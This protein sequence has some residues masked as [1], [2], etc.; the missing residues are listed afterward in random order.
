MKRLFGL[1]AKSNA[2]ALMVLFVLGLILLSGWPGGSPSAASTPSQPAVATPP[3]PDAPLTPEQQQASFQLAAGL[4]IDVIASEP[5]VESPV[6]CAFDEHARLWVAEYRDYPNG[7]P[8]GQPGECRIKVLEDT[9]GDGRF[10]KATIFADNLL[11]ANGVL[12]WKDGAIVTM[13]PKIVYLRDTDGDLK[14]DQ[15]EVLYEGFVAGNPQLRVSHPILGLDGWIYVA[16]GLR[17][18]GEVRRAGRTDQPGITLAGKD[19]RF[20]LLHD[21]AEAIP[22]MGQFGNTFDRWGHRFVCDNR[23]HLRHVV[24]AADPGSR[25]PLLAVPSVLQDTAGAD[26][27][28]IRVYPL[29]RNWTTSNLHAGQFTAACGV[30]VDKGGLLPPP[31]A[32][33]AFC[34]E[35]TGNLVH[36]SLLEP[37]GASFRS[38]PWKEGVEFLATKDEWFRPVS[39]TNAPDG[40][41]IVVDMYRAVIE[42][43]EFMPVELKNRPDLL[44]GKDRGRIWRIAPAD[45]PPSR[46]AGVGG[47]VD[48]LAARLADANGWVRATAQRLLLQSTDPK[49][50][51]AIARFA[52]TTDSPDA[53]I[54]AAYLLVMKEHSPE[55]VIQ[56]ML[57]HPRPE[58]QAHA[59]GLIEKTRVKGTPLPRELMTLAQSPSPAVRFAAAVALGAWD[60]PAIIPPLAAIA[61]KDAGDRWARLAVAS[62]AGQR[63]PELVALLLQKTEPTATADAHAPRMLEEFCEVIGSSRQKR[64]VAELL[65]AVQ[66]KPRAVQSAVV[67][68]LAEGVSRR[69]GSFTEFL[70]SVDDPQAN[71][72]AR[73]IL[74]DLT[75]AA[76]D[77]NAS[78]GERLEALR[79]MA[80]DLSS[81]TL[82]FLKGLI[83]DPDTSSPLKSAAIRALAGSHDPSLAEL[84]LKTWRQ[85]TPALRGEALDALLRRPER[86]KALLDAVELGKLKPADIDPVRAKRLMALKDK[87]LAERAVRLLKDSLPADRKEVLAQYRPALSL[88]ADAMRGLEA[89]RKACAACHVVNG[90]G[91]AVGP[92]ISDTRTKTPEMLLTD[93]LNPNAAI[94]ANYVAYTVLTRDGK[95]LQGIIA[96]ESAAS[97]TLKRENNQTDTLLRADIEEIRSSGQSLMPEGLEKNLSVQEMADLLRF[98][99]DWRYLDGRTPRQPSP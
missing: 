22:G 71:T 85:L 30:Y 67:R 39:L 60:E 82:S 16:N 33:A 83:G 48:S 75:Q 29:S 95:Q 66:S 86:I 11:F 88:P 45:R 68:G 91:T 12:P 78:E 76:Q 26:P 94:D 24:F 63:M 64:A 87:S 28:Q 79:L 8:P 42:H 81:S 73:R 50:A 52:H 43:P 47:D 25:N 1:L 55:P 59:A 15:T 31:F 6:A 51:P 4:R 98:L 77:P 54:L 21:R 35:P 10:D 3:G 92:D 70:S 96:A 72:I 53:L 57:R 27:T 56:K 80:Y 65:M 18:T 17:S 23:H 46:Y 19:F 62:S 84:L 93:I 37:Q 90:I 2:A 61:Q 32:H 38:R 13:A 5:L 97:I 14:A 89:F 9:T 69:G 44:W 34:C 74:S 40:S 36:C 49:A 99:K 41:L 7:P 20:D 58:V